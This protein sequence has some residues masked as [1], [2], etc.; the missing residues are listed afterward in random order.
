[1]VDHYPA[2]FQLSEQHRKKLASMLIRRD[3]QNGEIIYHQNNPA[4]TG[5]FLVSGSVGIFRQNGSSAPDRLQY[6]TPGHGFGFESLV[7]QQS[8]RNSAQALETCMVFAL[9]TSDFVDLQQDHPVLAIK[10]LEI[11]TENLLQNLADLQDEF[12]S[13]TNKLTQANILV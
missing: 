9:L 10:L 5:Y 11:V 13:L 12:R 6:I 7:E 2:F 4:A 8:R 3:Y 1:M